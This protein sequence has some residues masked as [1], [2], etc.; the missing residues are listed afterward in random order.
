MSRTRWGTMGESEQ[1]DVL[2]CRTCDRVFKRA[3]H[4]AA[5]V[6]ACGAADPTTGYPCPSC[7]RLFSSRTA[8]HRHQAARGCDGGRPT[9]IVNHHHQHLHVHHHQHVHITVVESSAPPLRAFR[10][11]VDRDLRGLPYFEARMQRI[12]SGDYRRAIP[13]CIR[14]KHFNPDIPQNAN[15]RKP[16]RRDRF[17]EVYDGSQ[18]K[19][20]LLNDIMDALID[21]SQELMDE[22]MARHR[23]A[24]SQ[25]EWFRVYSRICKSKPPFTTAVIGDN[26]IDKDRHRAVIQTIKGAVHDSVRLLLYNGAPAFCGDENKHVTTHS[27]D[28]RCP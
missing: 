10:H 6:Q 19:L 5:H 4:L 7:N 14:L 11:E 21:S 15:V 3:C 23:D 8:R 27:D 25:R 1:Y 20:S 22:Y 9:L 12:V 2:R 17:A 16:N 26:T 24:S 28:R 18:W 13:D